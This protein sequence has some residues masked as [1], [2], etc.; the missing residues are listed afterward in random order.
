MLENTEKIRILEEA[1]EFVLST[2]SRCESIGEV[3]QYG[4]RADALNAKAPDIMDKCRNALD[5]IDEADNCSNYRFEAT[6]VD[7]LKMSCLS[8]NAA[9]AKVEIAYARFL[10]GGCTH[11][12]LDI[13]GVSRVE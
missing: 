2:I 8:V 11:R 7:G 10:E 1:L 13:V 5:L 12:E 6:F 3:D 4:S 9:T